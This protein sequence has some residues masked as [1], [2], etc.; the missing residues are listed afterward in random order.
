MGYDHLLVAVDAATKYVVLAKSAGETAQAASELLINISTRFGPLRQVTTDRG[1]TFISN[2]FMT[3]SHGLAIQFKPVAAKQPPA[4]WMVERVNRTIKDTTTMLCQGQ[5]DAWPL[6]V[7]EVEYA[8]NTRP[9]RVTKYSFYELVY[10]R[11]PPGPKYVE[12]LLAEDRENATVEYSVKRLKS[13]IQFLQKLA[14]E[15]QMRAAQKQQSY[16]D[17]HAKAHNFDWFYTRSSLEK[18]VT[19]KL[20]YSWTVPYKIKKK[21]APVTYILEDPQGKQLPGTYHARHF[22]K[23]NEYK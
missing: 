11:L 12:E 9:S 3:A 6:H 14:H 23:V 21:L 8:I 17:A 5:G 22:L 4:N 10:G 15:N 1:Q 13:R 20:K 18:G 16:H 7:K 2:L 19:S